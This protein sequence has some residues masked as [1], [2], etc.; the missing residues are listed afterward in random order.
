MNKQQSGF[1][2]IELVMV[3]V[4]LGILAATALPKFVDL[5]S[6]ANSSVA[7]G[8]G[9]ALSS[10]GAINYSG[11]AAKNFVVTTDV[12]VKVAKCSDAKDLISPVITMA[13][14]ALPSPTVAKSFY[15]VTDTALT[16]AG[17]TTQCAAVYGDGNVGGVPFTYTATGT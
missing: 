9:G 1:T 17:K 2:L 11:C 12:C 4:I 5:R 6:D 15:I 16:A 14:G 3:I 8:Y 13:V 10:A 7:Q